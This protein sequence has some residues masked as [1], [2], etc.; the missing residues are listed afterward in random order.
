[1]GITN[2]PAVAYHP[3]GSSA[4]V[5]NWSDTVFRY[6][7][8][9]LTQIASAGS[10]VSWRDVVWV[11]NDKAVLL[12][13]HNS[14]NEGRLYVWN[15]MT[16]Q[17]TE[18]S[19]EK[20]AGGSYEALDVAAGG[21]GKL[22]ASKPSSG[23]GYIAYLWDFT[24]AAGRTNVKAKPT[25]AGC[26]D[27]AWAT[28][29]FNGTAVAVVCGLNGATLF[30]LDSG[31]FFQD[32]T[33]NSG[34]VSRISARPQRDYALLVGSSSYR[35]YRYQQGLWTTGSSSPQLQGIF[36]VEFSS[37][38]NR[39]LLFGRALG[40]PLTGRVFEFRHDLMAASDFTDVSI[41]NFGLPPYN[42]DGNV[43]L[44]DASWTPGCDGGLLV[45][46]INTLT[47]KKGYVIRF[48]VI[49]GKSC[50]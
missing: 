15:E 12:G 44:N 43:Y 46:G 48:S 14:L 47:N 21:N 49:N 25:S 10:G 13:R 6:S 33:G 31:G 4:L 7:A 17:L 19:A 34:N 24:I 41:P 3:S 40:N 1:F 26:Q 22:L 5:L 2:P 50:P 45:G 20:F 30:H 28:D 9:A 16:S 37:D 27:L 29:A 11:D 36:D 39:A 23:S 8:G 42:A 38:G 32:Y 18:L 35:A